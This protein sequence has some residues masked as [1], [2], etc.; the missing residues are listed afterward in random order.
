MPRTARD[1]SAFSPAASVALLKC[2]RMPVRAFAQLSWR[3]LTF[4]TT[5]RA[6][7]VVRNNF[8]SSSSGPVG[9]EATTGRNGLG[10]CGPAFTRSARRMR[11][12]TRAVR[13]RSPAPPGACG[14]RSLIVPRSTSRPPRGSWPRRLANLIV[15][16]DR[17][18]QWPLRSLARP[19]LATSLSSSSARAPSLTAHRRFWILPAIHASKGNDVD[20]GI[21]AVPGIDFENIE[22][23]DG[24]CRGG[25]M[26]DTEGLKIVTIFDFANN[27]R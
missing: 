26:A 20:S 4:A 23:T 22:R 25:E 14:W 21:G 1:E 7:A 27:T 18:A 16:S 15:T 3:F 5:A 6:L 9:F 11:V 17:A 8:P 12:G 24:P 10:A 2:Q 19:L 13:R